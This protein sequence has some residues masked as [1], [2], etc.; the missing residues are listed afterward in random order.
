MTSS[1]QWTLR[2]EMNHFQNE[3]GESRHAPSISFLPWY[4]LGNMWSK[5]EIATV[6][7]NGGSLDTRVTGREEAQEVNLHQILSNLQIHL[8][9]WATEISFRI[10][11]LERSVLIT[12]IKA[13]YMPTWGKAP[14]WPAYTSS[15]MEWC[16]EL[17]ALTACSFIVRI[18]GLFSWRLK[19]INH[20]KLHCSFP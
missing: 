13:G 5:A 18:H 15:Q 2:R 7:Q 20:L 8:F 12:L 17:L 11:L 3:A 14:P 1:K 4:K 19:S 9:P 6:S 16:A 10:F